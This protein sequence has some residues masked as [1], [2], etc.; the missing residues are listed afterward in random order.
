MAEPA[1]RRMT[2]AEFLEWDDGTDRRYELAEGEIV[3]MAPTSRRH[4]GIAL[5]LGAALKRRV[6][7][8]CWVGSEAG[9]LLP[10]RNDAWYEADLAVTCEPMNELQYL[11]APRIVVE[12]SS[13]S[14]QD[15]D[16][17]RKLPDYLRVESIEDILF[18]SATERLVRYWLR[19]EGQ[20]MPTLFRDGGLRLQAFGIELPLDEI[21]EGSGL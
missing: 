21:Y 17:F 8:P 12:I 19:S 3:A 9:I 10:H 20:Q 14:T 1:R 2:V 11:K 13:P 15:H 4:G 5:N 7:P 6:P 16:F 18:V